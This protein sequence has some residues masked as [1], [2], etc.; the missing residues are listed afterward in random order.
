M[1]DYKSFLIPFKSKIT[2]IYNTD[3]MLDDY[4]RDQLDYII[5][6]IDNMLTAL[7]PI[8]TDSMY[9]LISEIITTASFQVNTEL[10]KFIQPFWSI[11]S[12][13]YGAIHVNNHL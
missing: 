6:I 7:I 13:E 8:N 11:V 9:H 12:Q 5:N 1:L 10:L 2:E 4:D 3:F